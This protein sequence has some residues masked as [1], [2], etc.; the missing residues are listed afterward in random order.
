MKIVDKPLHRLE[1]ANNKINQVRRPSLTIFGGHFV[2]FLVTERCCGTTPIFGKVWRPFGYFLVTE[3]CCE[4]TPIFEK[5]YCFFFG[6]LLKS[7][8]F[9]INRLLGGRLSYS[10]AHLS[11]P[12]LHLFSYFPFLLSTLPLPHP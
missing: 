9:L 4:P 10:L 7:L 1:D 5:V 8:V 3:H 11:I 2:Y 6:C 12:I